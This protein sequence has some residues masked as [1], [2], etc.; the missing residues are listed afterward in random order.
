VNLAL[1]IPSSPGASQAVRGE[2][3]GRLAGHVPQRRLDDLMIVVTELVNNAVEH[4]PTDGLVRLAITTR[5]DGYV[6]G[7][8]EDEGHGTIAM[9]EMAGDA[10]GGFGLRI[11]D[12]FTDRWAVYEGSTHVWFEMGTGAGHERRRFPAS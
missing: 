2:L 7:E 5:P 10:D 11:V 8:I 6:R 3:R 4:G 1:E 12:V 9:R